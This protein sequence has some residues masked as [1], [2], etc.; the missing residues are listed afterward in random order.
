MADFEQ[1][2]TSL[3]LTL[4]DAV[5]SQTSPEDRGSLLLLQRCI[6]RSGSYIYLEIGSYLG[7]TLQPHLLDP[8][9]AA[10]Y[11]I[12]KRPFLQADEYG[13]TCHCPA[14]STQRMLDGLRTAFPKSS[15]E[16]IRTF[17]C[18]AREVDQRSFSKEP[19]LC[20]IDGEHSD[21]AVFSDFVYCL[22]VCGPDGMIAFHDANEVVGGLGRIKQYLRGK[23][24]RFEGF[25]LPKRV[26]VILLNGAIEMF[27][28]EIRQASW[29]ESRY[30][31]LARWDSAITKV[32]GRH[33][34]LRKIWQTCR[35][36][37]V[38]VAMHAT[39]G[40][41]SHIPPGG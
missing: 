16:K 35:Q 33:P 22:N 36:R 11:S 27:G 15:T 3:D 17:D 23:G 18:D 24:I 37:V 14:N 34:G 20:L 1:R 6:R 7:G 8:Q 12:D 28:K 29:N 40:N 4:F 26:F 2:I 32:V 21:S 19:D 13:S 39:S 38:R 10:I 25:V 41:G 9:C 30:M 5:P 31:R